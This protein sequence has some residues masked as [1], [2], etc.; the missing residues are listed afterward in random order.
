MKNVNVFIIGGSAGTKKFKIFMEKYN[1]QNFCES[2]EN[3]IKLYNEENYI[4]IKV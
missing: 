1:V 4:G 3:F 2:Y